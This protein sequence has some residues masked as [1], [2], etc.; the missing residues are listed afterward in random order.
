MFRAA[1]SLVILLLA[2]LV[3]AQYSIDIRTGVG[4]V[5]APPYTRMQVLIQR[6]DTRPFVGRIVVDLGASMGMPGGRGRRGPQVTGGEVQIIQEVALEEGGAARMFTLDIP[7]GGMIAMEV[8]LERQVSGS[9]YETVASVEDAPHVIYDQRKLVGFVSNTRLKVAQ[10]FLFFQAVEIPYNE[11]PESWKPLA[12]FDAIIIN[13][14]RISR[15]Q[16]AALADYMAAGG[17]V[18][19]SPESRASF[20]PDTPA[21]SLL[22]IPATT[23]QK[24]VRLAEYEDLLTGLLKPS[25]FAAE[26]GGRVPPEGLLPEDGT[27]PLPEEADPGQTALDTPDPES[28]MLLWPE[29]GRAK[30]ITGGKGL[31]SIARVGAGNLVLLHTDI[32]GAPFSTSDNVPTTACVK[33]LD[34]ALNAVAGRTGRTP[35]RILTDHD[36]RD[37]MDIAGRR[38]PGRDWLVIMMLAYVGLAG[39]GLFMLAR[40]L[41][42]PE[43]Y[44]AALLLAALVSVGLVFG[45]GEVFKRSGDRVK[46]V[47][48][49]VSDETTNRNALF[50]LGCAYAVDGDH[51][52]F[53][54]S[55]RMA[56]VPAAL[57]ARGSLRGMP[58]DPLAYQTTYTGGESHTDVSDLARWQNVFFVER[59]PANLE[60]YEISVLSMQGALKVENRTPH[61][62]RSCVLLVG[63]NGAGGASCEWH[64]V[65]RMGAAGTADADYTFSESTRLQGDVDQLAELIGDD[66]ADLELETLGALFKVNRDDPLAMAATLQSIEGRLFDTGVLPEEG[67]FLLICLLPA[68]ALSPGSLGAQGVDDDDVAQVNIW[69]VRG[70]VEGR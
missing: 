38:I 45:L 63:G 16:S 14:D 26:S 36:V 62:L 29:S 7:I 58:G 3:M 4:G 8:R 37:T 41:K 34:F 53:V 64:Y 2:P 40:K 1:L 23:S 61:E 48:I 24:T 56:F 50:T 5:V 67:E 20:N 43:L 49:L 59:E 28:P 60:G 6:E 19:I 9:Y 39:G 66:A 68:D 69:M 70:G 55:R 21:G 13:D 47:R 32:S 42:R 15:A 12:G 46:A 22:R 51:Y 30:P 18:I 33:L 17:T 10:P 57:E 11:L 27:V 54:N 52:Q 35:E 31:V 65:A 25:G 44:P